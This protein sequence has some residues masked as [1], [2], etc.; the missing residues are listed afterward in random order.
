ME[1]A[2]YA[3]A[4]MTSIANGEEP[5]VLSYDQE[6]MRDHLTSCFNNKEMTLFPSK[7]RKVKSYEHETEL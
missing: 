5:A 7:W 2:L 6:E 1:C 3:T 4:Y